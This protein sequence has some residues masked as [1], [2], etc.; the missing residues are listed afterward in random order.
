ML[1]SGFLWLASC[2][3][4]SGETITFGTDANGKPITWTR[5]GPEDPKAVSLRV[6]DEG[7]LYV[8]FGAQRTI[9]GKTDFLELQATD[10]DFFGSNAKGT[11]WLE[12]TWIDN[13]IPRD[14]SI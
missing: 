13:N 6:D 3:G 9:P 2:A 11:P 4:A 10:P 1:A 7:R 5:T 12:F 14:S 8:R